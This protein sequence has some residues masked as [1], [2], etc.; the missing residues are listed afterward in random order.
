[1][2]FSLSFH[3][4]LYTDDFARKNNF[5]VVAF[6]YLRPS[7]ESPRRIKTRADALTNL[8]IRGK[9]VPLIGDVAR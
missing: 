1:V 9:V 7:C 6:D 2:G 4:V 8:L 5:S 3:S